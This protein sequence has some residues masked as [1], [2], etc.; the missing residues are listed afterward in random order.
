MSEVTVGRIVIGGNG[1]LPVQTKDT[2]VAKVFELRDRATRH[3]KAM[4]LLRR[5]R[6]LLADVNHETEEDSDLSWETALAESI[7]DLIADIDA[8][9]KP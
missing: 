6:T 8:V 7:N 5:A 1:A 4:T 2:F 3:E 9:L